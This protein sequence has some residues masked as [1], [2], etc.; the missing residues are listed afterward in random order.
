[1]PYIL[2]T[3][4]EPL[5]P[6]INDLLDQLGN[7]NAGAGDFNYTITSLLLGYLD[8]HGNRYEHFNT[9]HGILNCVDQEFYRRW[10]ADYE[11]EAKVRNGD[12]T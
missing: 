12:V 8:L 3:R 10:T 1:M 7:M 2:K 4:R 9:V 6:L 5:D 11:N